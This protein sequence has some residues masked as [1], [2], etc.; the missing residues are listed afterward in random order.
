MNISLAA[1]PVFRIGSLPVTNSLL[2][3]WIVTVFLCSVAVAVSRKIASVPRGL[4]NLVESLVEGLLSYADSVTG[5]RRASLR[6]FPVV[7]SIFFFV[8]IGNWI[9]LLPGVGTVGIREVHEGEAVLVPILRAASADL[10]F[11]LALAL[12]SVIAAQVYG[13]RSVGTLA[14][15][16]K[17]FVPPWRSPYVIGTFVGILEFVSEFAKVISF[18][19]RL[20]GN[21]FAGE[22]LL[23]VMGLLAPFLAPVPFLFL[24]IF[25]GVVQAAVF[26]M[27]SL[28]FF[29]IATI[30]HGE[31]EEP[32][33]AAH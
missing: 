10:N 13:M 30:S 22:V 12:I 14:Y 2:A 7:A 9:G 5:D 17:F 3:G 11:T 31:G 21:V 6:F 24:E 23:L 8:L 33:A 20:F 28:V 25:V 27:L 16:G 19:F 18:S 26:A 29:T 32:G 15:W 4:Q 1:E